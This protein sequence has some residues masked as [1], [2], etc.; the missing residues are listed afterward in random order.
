MYQK[1]SSDSLQGLSHLPT[2]KTDRAWHFGVLIH[3]LTHYM[4][5]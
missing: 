1:G 4:K 2:I 5:R 3:A